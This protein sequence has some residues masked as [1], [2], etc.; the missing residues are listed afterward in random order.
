MNW[1][2]DHEQELAEVFAEAEQ[3]VSTFPAPLD[4]LGHAYLAKF[5]GSK[6]AS[7]KNYICY[8]LPFWMKDIAPLQLDSLK[9]LSLANVFVM[10]YY[11]IQDDIMDSTKN[12]HANKLPLANLFHMQ[13]LSI[14]RE[15]FPSDSPFWS[16]YNAYLIE[17]SE[18][19]TN[20]PY[21]DYFNNDI[22]KVAKKASPVKNA[23]AAALLLTH[24]SHLIP[25]ATRAIELVLITL[26]ML[27]DWADW[28]VDMAEGSYNCLLAS[29]R[30][31]LELPLQPPLSVE[32]VKQHIYVHDFLETYG[33][34]ATS[35]HLQLVRLSLPMSQ[36]IGFHEAL[37]QNLSLGVREIKQGRE[38]L[39]LGGFNYFLSKLS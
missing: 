8:L 1:F 18:A 38:S 31:H 19:V 20:E 6:E 33:K 3:L 11:F 36:L 13:F 10:L 5:D 9:K 22:S 29:L 12:E 24:Q 23:S 30:A 7:T 17:W 15:M 32:T 25:T 27:D 28:E 16:H 35:H 14:Y 4:R 37:V 26:Q 34:M 21:S 39:A 2:Q